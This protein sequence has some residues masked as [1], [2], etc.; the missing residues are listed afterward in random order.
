M[1][2]RVRLLLPLLLLGGAKTAAAQGTTWPARPIRFIVPFGPGG[3][4]DLFARAVAQQLTEPLGQPVVVDNRPGAGAVIGTEQAAKA[5]PD[6]YTFLVISSTHTVNETLLPTRPY[7]LLRDFAGVAAFNATELVL[8][9]HPSVAAASV[10]DLL[11]LAR[12][13]PGRLHYA[14]SGTGTPAHLAGELF[15]SLAGVDLTHVPYKASGGARSD[16]LS[17][18]VQLM[19]DAIPTMLEHV[20]AGKVKALGTTGAQRSAILA[21][22][23]T[24]AEAGVA[25]F[26][27]APFLGLLAPK[28][29]P[30][31][32]LQRM[33]EAV[34]RVV[35]QDSLRQSWATQGASAL[36]MSPAAFEAY[37]Q[38]DIDR[39]GRVIRAANIKPD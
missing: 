38:Q 17:G 12:Q 35:R 3:P 1:K 8:V 4:A 11:R 2:T 5:A 20:R 26:E 7:A 14:S 19:F 16:L 34:A 6:G 30:P 10:Q 33:N 23:P 39:W 22:L 36:A 29:T 18:Q 13:Q 28:G 25:G 27:S 37:V 15:K 31:A 9:A 32:I 24:I 21:D